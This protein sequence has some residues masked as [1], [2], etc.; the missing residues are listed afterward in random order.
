MRAVKMARDGEINRQEA[1]N[2]DPL[3]NQIE[4]RDQENNY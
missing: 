3:G 4:W 1:E 2:H